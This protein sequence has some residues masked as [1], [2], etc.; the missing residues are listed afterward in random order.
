MTQ[1]A[2]DGFVTRGGASAKSSRLDNDR[3][4]SMT[5]QATHGFVRGD[6]TSA[7]AS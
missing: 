6:G 5:K 3:S 1:Q 7:K 4:L 2:R